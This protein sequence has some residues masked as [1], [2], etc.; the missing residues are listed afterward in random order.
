MRLAI[1]IFS[2]IFLGLS[3]ASHARADTSWCDANPQNLV[4][5]RGF[6]TNDFSA[7]TTSGF[8]VTRG[9]LGNL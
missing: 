1:S 7:W 3:T 8:D 5:N 4:Q 6:E 2:T 9:T